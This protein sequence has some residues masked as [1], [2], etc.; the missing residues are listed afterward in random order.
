M[1]SPSNVKTFHHRPPS[2]AHRVH[3]VNLLGL[4][5]VV[6]FLL[7]LAAAGGAAANAIFDQVPAGDPTYA[8]LEKLENAGLLP[9][10]AAQ[11]PLSRYDV[12]LD[13]SKARGKYDQIVLAQAG[14][15]IPPPPSDLSTINSTP[16]PTPKPTPV[17]LT[18]LAKT[19]TSLEEAYQY[20]LKAVKA[21][22]QSIQSEADEVDAKQYE[23]RKRIMGITEYP[24]LSVHGLGRA[25]GFSQQYVGPT[26]P[27]VIQPGVQQ[28]FG[29]LDLEPEGVVSKQVSWNAILRLETSF[30][31]NAAP[32]I[33]FGRASMDFS[34]EWFSADLGDF[35]EAY[36]PFTLWNRDTLDLKYVP[37]MIAREDDTAKYESFLN[38]EPEWPFRGVRIGTKL[39]WPN[40]DVLD[41][42]HVSTFADMIHNNAADYGVFITPPQYI[43][44]LFGG[45][46]G[47]KSKKWK[48]D[49]TTWQAD[50]ETYGI[51][52]DQPLDTTPGVAPYNPLDVTTWA[53]QYLIGSVKPGL[54]VDLGDGTTVGGSVEY[55]TSSY[56]DDKLDSNR[57]IVDNALFG[58]LFVQE[59][60]STVSFNYLYVGPY[61]YSPMAQTRQDAVTNLSNPAG[62]SYLN[63]PDLFSAPLRGQDFLTAIPR[64]GGIF[65]FYDRTQDNTFP[66]GLA[67]PNRKGIGIDADIEALDHKA[68]KILGS[69]YFV[70]EIQDDLVNNLPDTALVPVDASVGTSSVALRNFTYIN[71]G[72][73]LNVGP[74]LG[75]GRDVE[76]G[77]NVRM[78]QTT[79]W[80]GTLT[81]T[82]IIGGVRVEILPVW[83]V[84]AAFS[85]QESKGTE[86]GFNGTLWAQYPYLFDNS[87]LGSYAP[88]TVNGS[89][90]SWRFSN[91]FKVNPNSTI[92]LDADWTS[93]NLMPVSASNPTLINQF[94]EVTY[95][96]RF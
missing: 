83:E 16:T 28:S 41:E 71:A 44:W 66:Y 17:P 27:Y 53:H 70:Q 81:S 20:E 57:V 51:I 50:I 38:N 9:A 59:G 89:N 19:L 15:E 80:V 74:L 82:W 87:D 79:S 58:S 55:A 85:N 63:S 69:A 48:W 22:L 72:P 2:A 3:G 64:A 5:L 65:G 31:P 78:E 43:D 77:T 62:L 52:M 39:L 84:S 68:L 73:S 12:A 24:S 42:F 32:V 10:G 6:A 67:T 1:N 76:L 45:T 88:F 40:S 95:E 23:L 47:I 4:K 25:F 26:P 37:E 49:G 33:T 46:A 86:E 56:Q 54:K 61:Y 18:D 91:L 21:S 96:V 92:Y 13:I 36:T 93:G 8:S 60:A 94:Y 75:L 90:Q 14:D 30:Q 34:P 7:A 29:Y 35:D 11:P